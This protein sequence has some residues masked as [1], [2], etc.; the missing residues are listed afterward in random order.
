LLYATLKIP[1]GFQWV[2]NSM[3]VSN[4]CDFINLTTVKSER[5]IRKAGK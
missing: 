2:S 1:F 5:K 3:V 4:K